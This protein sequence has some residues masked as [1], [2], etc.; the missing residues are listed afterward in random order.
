MWHKLVLAVCGAVVAAWSGLVALSAPRLALAGEGG[1]PWPAPVP[2]W[3][4]PAPGEHPRLFFRKSDIPALRERAKT[5]EGQAILK[6]LRQQLNGSD[7]ETLCPPEMWTISHVAGYG[8]LY[9]IT[10][11]KKYADLGRR[12]M[13][14]SL[15]G[16]KRKEDTRYAFK[17]AD[18]ALRAGP[19]LGWHALGYDLCYDGWDEAFRNKVR[20]ALQFYNDGPNKSLEEL[21]RGSR[22]GPH[23]N[24]WGMQIGGG[25]MALL[26]L[27]NDPGV[28]MARL[29]PL[30]EVSQ[31][32]FIRKLTE[33]YGDGGYFKEG[34][35]T[36]SMGHIAFLPAIQAWR[37]AGGKDFYNP[38]P[39]AQWASLRWLLGTVVKKDGTIIFHKR[40]G[41]PHNVWGGGLSGGNYFGIAF[42]LAT[43]VQKAA[44]LWFYNHNFKERDQR[45]GTPYDTGSYYPHHSILSFVNWPLG[46]QAVN[47]AECI[48][49]AS[50]DH[51]YGYCM[52]RNRWQDENDIVITLLAKR[53]RQH[54]KADEIGPIWITAYGRDLRWGRMNGEIK[55]FEVTQDG[56]G[57]VAVSDGTC[58]A[59]DF[60]QASGVEG[61]LVMTGPGAPGDSTV[62]VGGT[63]FSFK[64]LGPGAAP[65]P[66]VEGGKIHVGGQTVE[67]KNGIIVLGKTAGPWRGPTKVALD[68]VKP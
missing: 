57:I 47:P 42:G 9:V 55:H 58:L 3:K 34:D 41:Y 14:L 2:G 16:A 17:G 26:A 50:V 36:G 65:A 46:M 6:R 4:M 31:K 62:T 29:N 1:G 22:L 15:A 30:L 21:V 19:A 38:R 64:F 52:F 24:H 48:P 27:M 35:G 23:S 28:D 10:G 40:D 49:R 39:N 12:A 63:K 18:G 44:W 33:G 51:T 60:S 32:C 66:K 43:P 53:P 56:C 59:V 20:D 7:G 68:A 25:A 11:E 54:T 5:P 37:I 67:F 8:F 61:M 13:E 45:A